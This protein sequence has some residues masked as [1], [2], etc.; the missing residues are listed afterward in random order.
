MVDPTSLLTCCG[1][2]RFTLLSS[3]PF[4]P[5]TFRTELSAQRGGRE[6][7]KQNLTS[8]MNVRNHC[9]SWSE[10]FGSEVEGFNDNKID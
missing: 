9:G 3:L 6:N 8:E 7:Q 4:L 2:R 5:N 10:I 1:A